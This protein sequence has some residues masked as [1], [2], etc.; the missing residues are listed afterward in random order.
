MK[1]KKNEE[2]KYLEKVN[3]F[4]VEEKRNGEGKRGKHLEKE[5]ICLWRRRKRKR[6]FGEGICLWRGRKS[7]KEKEENM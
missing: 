7:E 5:N 4:F 1:E 6:I 2:G 3:L